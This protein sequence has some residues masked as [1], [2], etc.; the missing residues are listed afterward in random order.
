MEVATVWSPKEVAEV[1]PPKEAAAAW[2]P[3][4]IVAVKNRSNF[5]FTPILGLGH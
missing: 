1:W 5:I 2:S 3:R 4:E